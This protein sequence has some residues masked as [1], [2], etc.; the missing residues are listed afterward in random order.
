M[1]ATKMGAF[2]YRVVLSF[3]FSLAFAGTASFF[4]L[5]AYYLLLVLWYCCYLGYRRIALKYESDQQKEAE[6]VQQVVVKEQI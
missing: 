1:S 3:L 4:S 6:F 5:L 2:S